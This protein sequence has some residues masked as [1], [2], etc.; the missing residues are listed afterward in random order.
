MAAANAQMLRSEYST[1]TRA[2]GAIRA[3]SMIKTQPMM[4]NIME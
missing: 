4:K 3:A 1:A 2:E